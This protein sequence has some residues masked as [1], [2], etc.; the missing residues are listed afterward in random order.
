[1]HHGAK[2]SPE[3]NQDQFSH[4]GL[5]HYRDSCAPSNED[6]QR[7][8]RHDDGACYRRVCSS[9]RSKLVGIEDSSLGIKREMHHE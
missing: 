9:H 4:L 6:Y 8:R 3:R 7:L 1:M 5:P 2:Q